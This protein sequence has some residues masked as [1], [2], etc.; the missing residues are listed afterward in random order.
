MAEA[1][2]AT[3]D[4]TPTSQTSN[5]TPNPGFT[6]PEKFAGKT[7]EDIAKSYLELESKYGET[8]GKL[9]DYDSYSKIGKPE[10]IAQA[11]EW[12]KNM[13][14]ALDKGLLVPKGQQQQTAPV[15]NGS[16][17][18]EPW[19]ADDWAYKSPAEQFQMMAEHLQNQNK[20]YIDGIAKQYGDQLQGLTAQDARQ[21]S[22]LLKAIKTAIKN[23]DTDPEELL[24]QAAEYAQK[25]PEELIEMVLE[26]RGNTPASRQA[27]IDK[28][29]NQK[30]AEKIQEY[31]ARQLADI[32]A[33]STPRRP[34]FGQQA[35][36]NREAENKAI[37]EGLAKQGIKLL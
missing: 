21:K 31:E 33:Q 11:I 9:K 8:S 18:T 6:M 19:K 4:T 12:A 2:T 13:K 1:T 7:S 37:I 20:S 29:V 23:P 27:E 32:T 22:I 28:L 24:A 16:V 17:P 30:L 26:A 14:Q 34:G 10:D 36:K 15:Q 25:S 35:M 3:T 5:S